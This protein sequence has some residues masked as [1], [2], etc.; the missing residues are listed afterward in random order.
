[1]DDMVD[2]YFRPQRGGDHV[3]SESERA[4]RELASMPLYAGASMSRL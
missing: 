2:A 1:M 4:M 3:E